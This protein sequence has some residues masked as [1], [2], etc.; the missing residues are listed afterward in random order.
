MTIS[1]GCVCVE[2]QSSRGVLTACMRGDVVQ[3]GRFS[4]Y[5]ACAKGVVPKKDALCEPGPVAV[6]QDGHD[7]ALNVFACP[8]V[9]CVQ[10]GSDCSG[11]QFSRKGVQVNKGAAREARDT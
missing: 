2:Q 11:H 6:D 1:D 7:L 9:S 4:V 3:H 8:P 5:A 10:T